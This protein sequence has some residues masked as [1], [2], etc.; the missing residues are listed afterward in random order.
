MNRVGNKSPSQHLMA[1]VTRRHITAL[2]LPFVFQTPLLLGRLPLRLGL[3]WIY[4]INKNYNRQS[5][6]Q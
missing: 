3:G 2:R 4:H 1:A 6:A 5:W